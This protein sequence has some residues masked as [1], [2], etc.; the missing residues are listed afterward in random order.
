MKL[1]RVLEPCN[2]AERTPTPLAAVAVFAIAVAGEVVVVILQLVTFGALEIAAGVYWGVWRFHG[3]QI[4]N[5]HQVR[6]MSLCIGEKVTNTR[7]LATTSIRH[8][9]AT[10]ERA[11]VT[12]KNTF[13]HASWHASL[14]G[15]LFK[16]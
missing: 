11:R 12:T 15:D 5:K 8:W 7:V 2:V 1:I 9:Q 14:V 4:T 16:R 3:V 6:Q 10:N 13:F